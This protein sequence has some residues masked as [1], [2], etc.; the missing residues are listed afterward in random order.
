MKLLQNLNTRLDQKITR[1]Y[2]SYKKQRIKALEKELAALIAQEKAL[3]RKLLPLQAQIEAKK[4]E[5]T[6]LQRT[7]SSF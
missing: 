7:L 4:Q 3:L 6:K 2:G 1:L 5:K